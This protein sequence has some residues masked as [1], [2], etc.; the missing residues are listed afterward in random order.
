MH[1]WTV[2]HLQLLLSAHRRRGNSH[3][4]GVRCLFNETQKTWDLK[5]ETPRQGLSGGG[6][7]WGLGPLGLLHIISTARWPTRST[8]R[9][10]RPEAFI[11]HLRMPRARRTFDVRQPSHYGLP[12]DHKQTIDIIACTAIQSP[13]HKVYFF[14]NPSHPLRKLLGHDFAVSSTIARQDN[15]A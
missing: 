7:A 12:I 9:L 14:R 3:S 6:V 11:T 5:S 8:T 2:L 1:I 13:F 15:V 10:G 4:I